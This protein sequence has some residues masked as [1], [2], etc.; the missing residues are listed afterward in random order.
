MAG[1]GIRARDRHGSGVGVSGQEG[2]KGEGYRGMGAIEVS[3]PRTAKASSGSSILNLRIMH[4]A[5]W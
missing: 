4:E 2:Y 1:V 5:A 3:A